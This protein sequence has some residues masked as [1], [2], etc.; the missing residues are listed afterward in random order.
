MRCY[1]TYDKGEKFWIPGCHLA[2]YSKDGLCHCRVHEKEQAKKRKALE[3]ESILKQENKQLWKE[4][5]ALHRIID[6][7]IK[8][9]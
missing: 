5:A 6:K 8:K 7:L 1:W 9:K 4:N 2:F 3:P